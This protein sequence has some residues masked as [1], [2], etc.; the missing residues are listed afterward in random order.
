MSADFSRAFRALHDGLTAHADRDGLTGVKRAV[1]IDRG[2][3]AP[4]E[5][6]PSNPAHECDL[7][8]VGAWLHVEGDASLTCPVCRTEWAP[9]WGSGS[10]DSSGWTRVLAALDSGGDES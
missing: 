1:F 4:G 10:G 3:H 9:A 2:G 7:P 6:C 5:A 8:D